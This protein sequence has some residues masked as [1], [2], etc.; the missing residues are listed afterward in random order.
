ML[1]NYAKYALLQTIP[2][3]STPVIF[4]YQIYHPLIHASLRPVDQTANVA[5]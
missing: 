2:G 5:L 3:D 4:M 1:Q